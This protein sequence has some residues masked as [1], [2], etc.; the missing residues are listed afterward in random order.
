MSIAWDESLSI[1]DTAIDADHR[2]MIAMIACLEEAAAGL[3]DFAEIG[4][5]LDRL[6]ARCRDHFVREESL[7]D[8]IGFPG[9]EEHR[10]CHGLL[11]DR[12]D[13][14]VAHYGE[15]SDAVRAD[16]VRTLGDSLA[17]WMVGHITRNDAEYRPYVLAAD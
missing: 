14:L 9:R 15:G 2:E 8:R 5:V 10:L 13:S 7:L 4:R 1:G 6:V 3:P 17:T 11:L 16:I 12:L